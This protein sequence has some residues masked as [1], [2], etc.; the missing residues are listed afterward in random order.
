MPKWTWRLVIAT[1][2]PTLGGHLHP[3]R[4]FWEMGN[5]ILQADHDIFYCFVS[6]CLLHY[7]YEHCIFSRASYN[8][9]RNFSSPL[10]RY[11]SE[12][13]MP[14]I[15]AHVRYTTLVEPQPAKCSHNKNYHSKIALGWGH[16]VHEW[17]NKTTGVIVKIQI[18]SY[19]TNSSALTFHCSPYG[20]AQKGE[21]EKK[22]NT[23]CLH[24]YVVWTLKKSLKKGKFLDSGLIL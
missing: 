6:T 17:S 8:H 5:E 19:I 14:T 16:I 13:T 11:E 1:N 18:T 22:T 3:M 24:C 12:S 23:S 2:N 20:E 10:W 7:Q 21:G 9:K 15:A 4:S